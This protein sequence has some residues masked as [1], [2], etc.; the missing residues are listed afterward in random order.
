M[1]WKD[2]VLEEVDLELDILRF[3]DGTVQVRDQDT[4]T[5]VQRAWPMP[6]DVVVQAES[7]C[8]Q[9]R[10]LVEGGIEPFGAVGSE[11]LARFL[12]HGP[13]PRFR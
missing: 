6:S 8:A 4:F 7:T 10:T 12:A 11:W 2:D 13:S 9:L 3:T 5:Q 1:Q